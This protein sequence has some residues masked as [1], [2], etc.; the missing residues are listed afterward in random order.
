LPPLHA[1]LSAV[2]ERRRMH[3]DKCA[4]DIITA[5]LVLGIADEL[6]DKAASLLQIS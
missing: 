5:A 2:A 6:L 3:V 4:A 1:E